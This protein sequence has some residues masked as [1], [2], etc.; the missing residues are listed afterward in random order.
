MLVAAAFCP[1]PPL[2]VPELAAGAA[3]ELD[4]LRAACDAAVDAVLAAGADRVVVLGSAPQA[5]YYPSGR[6]DFGPYGVPLQVCLGHPPGAPPAAPGAAPGPGAAAEPG[7]APGPGAE[8]ELGAEAEPGAVPGP[9]A[10]AESGAAAGGG[11]RS[12]FADPANGAEPLPL[13]IALGAWL[14]ARR[15]DRHPGVPGVPAVGASVDPAG[16]CLPLDWSGAVG[17][18]V[19]GDGSARRV[20]TSPGSVDARGIPFDDAAAAALGSGDPDRL[21]AL[22][23]ALGAELLAAGTP[24][25]VAAGTALAGARYDA[26]LHYAGAP[27]GV[28]YLVATWTPA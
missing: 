12:G 18:L 25:W 24:A 17:L 23:L 6:G 27:Y 16:T 8:A 26:H 4:E 10:A 20:S 11:G 2:L 22:D 3:A 7:A 15:A 28:G 21:R 19:M 1:Q 13:P 5:C 14:L 9:G